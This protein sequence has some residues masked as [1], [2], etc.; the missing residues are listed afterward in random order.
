MPETR[1]AQAE[2]AREYGIEAFCYYHYW[3]GGKR[4]L[5]RPF[6]EVLR[7]GEPDFPFAFAGLIKH[8]LAYGMVPKTGC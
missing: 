7:S 1:I 2:M 4:L 3:F 8:G 6:N 5:E